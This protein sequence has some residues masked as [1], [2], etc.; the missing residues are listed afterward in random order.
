MKFSYRSNLAVDTLCSG[1][2]SH[3]ERGSDSGS[4]FVPFS[5]QYGGFIID[6]VGQGGDGAWSKEQVGQSSQKKPSQIM[7]LFGRVLRWFSSKSPQIVLIQIC[8]VLFYF[9]FPSKTPQI[10]L[11]QLNFCHFFLLHLFGLM[12]TPWSRVGFSSTGTS[13]GGS[14]VRLK[15]IWKSAPRWSKCGGTGGLRTV[16]PVCKV[17]E[18]GILVMLAIVIDYKV[19]NLERSVTS[20]VG[21]LVRS[22]TL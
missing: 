3:S 11:I 19:T 17:H 21:N 12:D 9:K 5:S 8:H 14:R 2:H 20:K 13:S 16:C 18:W 4:L 1:T 22:V 10:V 6:G 15:R 7:Y